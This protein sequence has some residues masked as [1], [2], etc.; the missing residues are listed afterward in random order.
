VVSRFVQAIPAEV[1]RSV[2]R[3]TGHRSSSS[4]RTYGASGSGSLAS[5]VSSS[6]NTP[7]P[8]PKKVPVQ[9]PEYRVGN[10]VFH[11]KFGE[12]QIAEVTPRRDGDLE[13]SVLFKKQEH[14][15]KRLIASLANMD[16]IS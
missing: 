1:M 7:E 14:G 11:Q 6:W 10:V 16:I 8:T 4:G 2:T 3:Q 12:G 15:Q 13:L 5:R 9:L